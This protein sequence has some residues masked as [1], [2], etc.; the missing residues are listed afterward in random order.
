MPVIGSLSGYD[1]NADDLV[2]PAFRQ[3]L[4]ARGYVEGRNLKAEYRFADG[5]PDRLPALA[6]DLV[7]SGVALVVAV[8]GGTSTT[9]AVRGV[10]TTIPVVFLT[11]NDPTQ[12]GLVPNLNRP[13][14]NTSGAINLQTLF[15]SK[16]MGL[17]HQLLPSA[18]SVVGLEFPHPQRIEMSEAQE[19]ARQFGIQFEV[20][21]A[22]TDAEIDAVF[23]SLPGMQAEALYVGASPLFF[24]RATKIVGQA[25]RLAIPAVYWRRE[26]ADAGGLMSYSTHAKE[27]YRVLGDYA[28]RILK[29]EKAGDLPVQQ[30]TRFELVINLKT[31]KALRLAVPPTLIA[32]ADEIIE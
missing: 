7:R 29:G 1:G 4:P 30:S 13:A 11:G 28:G 22:G 26:L 3:A 17:L 15:A 5:I 32:L 24:S 25:A 12:L 23:A 21:T 27:R 6:R 31:A 19:A 14:N 16:R 8:G 20:L 9:R 2:L 10:S 18:T